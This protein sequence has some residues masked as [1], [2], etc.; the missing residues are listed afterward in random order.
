MGLAGTGPSTSRTCTL[1]RQG[2]LWIPPAALSAI[3][4][5]LRNCSVTWKGTDIFWKESEIQH[6]AKCLLLLWIQPCTYTEKISCPQIPFTCLFLSFFPNFFFL[7]LLL[8]YLFLPFLYFLKRQS[9][10]KCREAAV[11]AAALQTCLQPESRT[12]R[13]RNGKGAHTGDVESDPAQRNIQESHSALDTH[14]LPSPAFPPLS[15]DFVA[16]ED[17]KVFR[18]GSVHIGHLPCSP[19]RKEMLEMLK[20]ALLCLWKFIH[21]RKPLSRELGK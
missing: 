8:F 7:K 14:S 4:G 19:G 18:E 6:P 13:S 10:P 16:G 1:C 20:A 11:A 9:C 3:F 2:W 17:P 12:P 21:T 5:A 15:M